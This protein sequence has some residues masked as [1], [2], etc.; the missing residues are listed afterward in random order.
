MAKTSSL[1][2]VIKEGP[3][4]SSSLGPSDDLPL[5]VKAVSANLDSLRAIV[6][7][8]RRDWSKFLDEDHEGA[9]SDE[10]ALISAL[11]ELFPK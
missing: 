9:G 11:F 8:R 4:V 2:K 6:N 5:R 3:S 10:K 7:D 1:A